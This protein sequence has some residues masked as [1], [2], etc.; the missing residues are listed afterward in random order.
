MSGTRRRGCPTPRRA[1][2]SAPGSRRRRRAWPAATSPA[3][4]TPRQV[5]ADPA[6]LSVEVAG[7]LV[8]WIGREEAAREDRRYRLVFRIDAGRIGLLRFEQ[9]ESGK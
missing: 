7:E 4:S 5:E 3:P 1:A 9:L 8:T 6:R 2:R